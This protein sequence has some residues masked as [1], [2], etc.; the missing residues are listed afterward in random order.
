MA[1]RSPGRID[2]STRAIAIEGLAAAPE[3]DH[4]PPNALPP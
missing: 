1:A 4:L 2:V 3:I